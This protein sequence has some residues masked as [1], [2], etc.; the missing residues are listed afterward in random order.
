MTLAELKLK[1]PMP[2]GYSTINGVVIVRD[3]A[4]TEVPLFTMLDFVVAMT[5]AVARK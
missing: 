5:G 1:H 2:W 3:A 4:G